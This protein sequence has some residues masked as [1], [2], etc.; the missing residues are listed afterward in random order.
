MAD[1]NERRMLIMETT[2]GLKDK[3]SKE[4]SQMRVDSAL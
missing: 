3:V 1:I 4:V 2:I